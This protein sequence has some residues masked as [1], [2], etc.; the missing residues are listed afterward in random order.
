M[1]G[2]CPQSA[3]VGEQSACV[4]E[5][6]LPFR[7]GWLLPRRR[8]GVRKG[9]PWLFSIASTQLAFSV[10]LQAVGLFVLVCACLCVFVS[11]R[12][13]VLCKLVQ[14]FVSSAIGVINL[15]LG[16]GLLSQITPTD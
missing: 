16:Y 3:Y 9:C 1:R 8:L 6:A 14:H 5:A 10:F 4:G 7:S 2:V 13:F 11:V 12:V 15:T